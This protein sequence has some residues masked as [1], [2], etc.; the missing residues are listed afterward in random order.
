M[1]D[2]FDAVPVQI[3]SVPQLVSLVQGRNSQPEARG[4]DSGLI[5]QP[6]L[7]TVSNRPQALDTD[8]FPVVA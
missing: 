7:N 5:P 1:I 2:T 6:F 8:T 3:P 4:S